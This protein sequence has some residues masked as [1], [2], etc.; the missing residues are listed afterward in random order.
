[1]PPFG[2]QGRMF[3]VRQH[4]SITGSHRRIGSGVTRIVSEYSS[5]FCLSQ[6]STQPAVAV[7]LGSGEELSTEPLV[8]CWRVVVAPP[9]VTPRPMSTSLF[10]HLGHARSVRRRN[11]RVKDQM[12]PCARSLVRWAWNHV[13]SDR[14]DLTH[15][16][17]SRARPCRALHTAPG[18][19]Q[20]VYP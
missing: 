6:S 17:P 1:M 4:P 3:N 8:Q 14:S 12:Q 15:A 19:C 5:Q 10:P 7:L 13:R 18:R 2:A 11:S 9:I 20:G 16:M